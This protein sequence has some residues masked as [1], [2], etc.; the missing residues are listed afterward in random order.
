MWTHTVL[1][2]AYLC[3]PLTT[4]TS[5]ITRCPSLNC[6]GQVCSDNTG[7]RISCSLLHHQLLSRWPF[8]AWWETRYLYRVQIVWPDVL[9]VLLR[10]SDLFLLWWHHSLCMNLI[11]LIPHVSSGSLHVKQQGRGMKNETETQV[12]EMLRSTACLIGLQ[13]QPAG[14]TRKRENSIAFP[15]V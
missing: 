2:W 8:Q 9:V 15:N 13:V 10:V 12:Y 1:N 7:R 11:I 4:M 5:L 6:A 14:K 3:V